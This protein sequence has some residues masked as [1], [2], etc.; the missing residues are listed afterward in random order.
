MQLYAFQKDGKNK[1]AKGPRRHNRMSKL[2]N[3]HAYRNKRQPTWFNQMDQV[4]MVSTFPWN[5]IFLL[6]I[7][8]H[9]KYMSWK[10]CKVTLCNRCL[11]SYNWWASWPIRY[12][13]E[14][15]NSEKFLT[16]SISTKSCQ[17]LV[18]ECASLMDL[19]LQKSCFFKKNL[20]SRQSTLAW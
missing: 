11:N 15:Y 9:C 6:W 14:R 4:N 10:A 18:S 20:L 19:N 12:I 13:L 5:I 2:F 8:E 3:I 16:V 7:C 1:I 17:E